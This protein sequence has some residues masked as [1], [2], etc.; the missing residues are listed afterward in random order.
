M[1]TAGCV[2]REVPV[3]LAGGGL[4]PRELP[5]RRHPKTKLRSRRHPKTKLS[6]PFA[7]QVERLAPDQRLIESK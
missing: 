5:G 1:E 6:S 3:P 7:A 4:L 2:V